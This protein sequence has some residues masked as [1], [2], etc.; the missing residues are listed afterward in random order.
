MNLLELHGVSKSFGGLRALKLVSFNVDARQIVGVIGPNGAGKTTLFGC[1]SGF[2]RCTSGT[3]LL[4]GRQIQTLS[5]HE[6]CAAGVGRTFQLV[7]PFE[8]LS[9]I[10]N[11]MVGAMLRHK[12]ASDA[13]AKAAAILKKLDM[14]HLADRRADGLGVADLR[15]MEVARALSTEPALLLLD[16]MLA[17]LTSVESD[18]M[19][20]RFK[21]LRDEG[22]GLLVIEHSVPTMRA[23]CDKV[24]VL[25]FGELLA[26]GT[27]T[28]VLANPQVQEA[29]LGKND[30]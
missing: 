12:K 21:L 11:V 10:E 13:R 26:A 22:L 24:V 3:V 30:E 6:I 20:S 28:E 14:M 4:K 15:A 5:P 2:H 8:G 19:H 25:N 23:L 18:R 9:V 17:G 7:R 27:S 1:I 16:E 29:Y